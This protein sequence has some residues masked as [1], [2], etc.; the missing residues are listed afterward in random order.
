MIGF[1]LP[2]VFMGRYQVV[3]MRAFLRK[4]AALS[5]VIHVLQCVC[6][7]SSVGPLLRVA[8]C[9]QIRSR[10]CL[11]ACFCFLTSV[12]SLGFAVTML[13]LLAPSGIKAEAREANGCLCI[14]HLSQKP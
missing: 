4:E 7:F 11:K 3:K 10:S 13:T 6:V 5:C 14:N 2:E 1:M 9:T 12:L 8:I